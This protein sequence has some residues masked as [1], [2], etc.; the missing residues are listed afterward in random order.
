MD[1]NHYV[2]ENERTW[3]MYTKYR[4]SSDPIGSHGSRSFAGRRNLTTPFYLPQ[5]IKRRIHLRT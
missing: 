3:A 4:Y 1:Q 2:I 5:H